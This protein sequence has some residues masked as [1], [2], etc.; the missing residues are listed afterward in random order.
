MPEARGQTKHWLDRWLYDRPFLLLALTSLF[1]AGNTVLGRFVAGH[2]P[3]VTLASIRWGG[4]FLILLPFAAP[5]L[6][7]DWPVIGA[8]SAC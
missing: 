3:P 6:R 5:H 7:R 8:T 2:V 1:W 4:A